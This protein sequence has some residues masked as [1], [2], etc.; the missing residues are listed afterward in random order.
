[1]LTIVAIV[2]III[3]VAVVAILAYAATQPDFFRVQRTATVKA[4]AEKIFPSST[5]CVPIQLG[6]RS[7]RT[8]T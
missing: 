3:I 4:P 2:A 8:P 7:R 5:I 1:M 6:R